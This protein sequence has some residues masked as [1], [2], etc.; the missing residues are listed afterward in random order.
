MSDFQLYIIREREAYLKSLNDHSQ[1][2]Y[3]VPSSYR[4]NY[5]LSM[6]QIK[7]N[8]GGGVSNNPT[9]YDVNKRNVGLMSSAMGHNSSS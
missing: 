5:P 1:V 3:H 9:P 2:N 8:G 6:S 7:N 4:D